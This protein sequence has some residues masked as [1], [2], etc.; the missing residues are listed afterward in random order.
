M[1]DEAKGKPTDYYVFELCD[2]G[3]ES[4]ERFEFLP[5]RDEGG[6]P[7][8][9]RGRGKRE[10]IDTYTGKGDDAKPGTFRAVA[11]SAWKGT[12]TNRERTGMDHLFDPGA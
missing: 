12:K 11:V 8:V 5:V 2:V 9:F 3:L 1:T 4:A 10:A 6:E 7:V